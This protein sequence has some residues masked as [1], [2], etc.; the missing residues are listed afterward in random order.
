[1]FSEQEIS[2]QAHEH[3]FGQTWQTELWV[4]VTSWAAIT[5]NRSCQEKKGAAG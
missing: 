3:S 4:A 2:S 5:A 1:M